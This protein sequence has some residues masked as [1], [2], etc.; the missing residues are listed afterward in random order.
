M[1]TKASVEKKK[2]KRYGI[3]S[4]SLTKS[5]Q[6]FRPVMKRVREELGMKEAEVIRE[7]VI[8]Y[9]AKHDMEGAE[10]YRAFVDLHEA[11]AKAE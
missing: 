1:K 2:R 9:L 10:L 11:R 5:M 8:C 4:A 3:W 7:A 6:G